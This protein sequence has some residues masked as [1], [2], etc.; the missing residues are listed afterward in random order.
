[1]KKDEKLRIGPF[2]VEIFILML[3]TMGVYEFAKQIMYSKAC[4]WQWQA[5]TVLFASL[6]ATLIAFFL[7]SQY[8]KYN[9]KLAAEVKMLKRME[10]DLND[11]INELGHFKDLVLWWEK[12]VNDIQEQMDSIKKQLGKDD[13]EE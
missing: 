12:R 1:M 2:L 9:K 13:I 6:L 10:E 11:K 3:V 4:P 8:A 5:M 7:L